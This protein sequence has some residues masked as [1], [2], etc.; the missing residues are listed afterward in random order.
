MKSPTQSF[1]DKINSDSY[2]AN[3]EVSYKRR[4][5][6]QSTS[7][8]VW[9]GSW[10]TISKDE[11]SSLT[12]I[13]A[14]LDTAQL[15]EFKISNIVLNLRDRFGK[16]M[17][18]NVSGIFGPDASSSN[19][20]EA[21]WTKFRVRYSV[22]LSAGTTE[23]LA[24]FVGV[25]TDFNYDGM[26]QLMTIR[27]D[28]LES[29]LQS[30]NAENVSTSV[31]AKNIGTG[32]NIEVNF[33]TSNNGV[34]IIEEVSLDG[35]EKKPGKDFSISQLNDPDV[36]AKI[37][38]V[39][40]PGSS[41]VVRCSY[42][43]WKQDQRIEDLVS[44]L[45]DEAG[46]ATGDQVISEVVFNS[47]ISSIFTQTD[48]SDFGAGTNTDIQVNANDFKFE[49]QNLAPLGNKETFE[50][51]ASI[52]DWTDNSTG[53]TR[54]I[55]SGNLECTGNGTDIEKAS[56]RVIGGWQLLYRF[57]GATNNPSIK[58]HFL[59]NSGSGSYY[60]LIAPGQPTIKLFDSASGE[61]GSATYSST[62][63][64]T[65][66]LDITRYP[67]G[68]M[69][70]RDSAFPLSTIDVTD[71]TFTNCNR[72]RIECDADINTIRFDSLTYPKATIDATHVSQTLD[73]L[74]ATPASWGRLLESATANGAT[75]TRSTRSSDDA[76]VWDSYV[77][78]NPNFGINS[79]LK[80]YLQVR[81]QISI[82][83][84]QNQDPI[85]EQYQAEYRTY[86]TKIKL[87]NFTNKTVYQ[88]IK[89]FGK[90]S[91]FEFGFNEIEKFFFRSKDANTTID[92]IIKR[93]ENL[94]TLSQ[95]SR[96]YDRTYSEVIAN[97]GSFQSKARVTP[98]FKEAPTARFSE[99]RLSLD[100][101]G[102]L[103]DND[104]DVATGIANDYLNRY[105]Q[106]R[107]RFRAKTKILP[108]LDLSDTIQLLYESVN[109]DKLWF[110]G[111]TSVYVGQ[112]DIHLFGAPN[113][114]AGN[115][116]CK[117][118]GIRHDILNKMSDIELE[119][120]L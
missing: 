71:T 90:F 108:H 116:L 85:V 97:Y 92:D 27:V 58:I 34:G 2:V 59:D 35:I 61:I 56:D 25:A 57:D 40:A 28:G 45:L 9:E 82:D 104:T 31:T 22:E 11:I 112:Q 66:I 80:R 6:D 41:V 26:S 16:W 1:L 23:E 60:V 79:S 68:R 78:A 87:A 81:Y 72:I 46:I 109:P 89:D 105:R 10:T 83:T 36:P 30:A 13:T 42:K 8:Y 50:D 93:G 18:Q 91:D 44:D 88:A 77:T 111:D 103:I 70:V 7:A 73:A 29:L 113:F 62:L 20:Y 55:V 17:D 86:A 14:K 107:R 64:T 106:P 33:T 95:T 96:G 74:I 65:H 54:T 67:T 76:V 53:G 120:I 12:P 15:N 63:N 99:R 24:M 69:R 115:V 110:I 101:S 94:L 37:T 119:E 32:D 38:F 102:I 51:F 4:Y 48:S 5:W 117:I 100:S 98:D 3:A 84:T 19:G 75:I 114:M 47:I 49:F 43:Y 21:Y 118:V 52:V 39:T